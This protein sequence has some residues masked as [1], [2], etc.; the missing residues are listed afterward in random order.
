MMEDAEGN[1]RP[2]DAAAL[3]EHLAMPPRLVFLSACLSAAAGEGTK[4]LPPSAAEKRAEAGKAGE[5]VAHSLATALVEGGL[6]AVL[7]WDGP[8]A[9]VAATAFAGAFYDRLADR[10]DVTRAVAD[11]RRA[12]L[13]A[14]AEGMR[15][16]WH[17]ARLWLGPGGGGPVVGGRRKRSMLPATYG[18]KEF[19]APDRKKVRVAS[20]EMFVGRRRQLQR[21]LRALRDRRH[22]GVLVH[23]MGRLGKSSLA[24]RIA[25]RRS[26]MALAV[27]FEHYDALSVA[28]ALEVALRD[29]PPARDLLAER[30]P[31]VRADP[32][33]LETL[34]I[35]LL[36]G[37]CAQATEGRPVLLVID[38]LERTLVPSRTED[39]P[40]RPDPEHAPVLRMILSAFDPNRTDSRLFFTSRFPFALDGLQRTLETVPLPPLSDTEQRKLELRQWAAAGGDRSSS[41]G[42]E[43]LDL[44]S[45]ARVLGRG[46]PGLQDLLGQEQVLSEA[47]PLAR[48]QEVLEQTEAWLEGGDLPQDTRVQAF[49]ENLGIETLLDLAGAG[50]REL[51]RATS[52]F[53]LPVPASVPEGLADTIGGS[54]ARLRDLGLLDVFEDLVDPSVQALAVNGLALSRLEPL[55]ED[56]RETIATLVAPALYAAWGGDEGTDWRPL[57]ADWEL[58]RLGMLAKEGAVVAVC[59]ANAVRAL[60]G[61]PAKDAAAVG[62]D[63]ITLLDRLGLDAPWRL[64]SRTAGSLATSGEGELADSLLERGVDAMEAKRAAGEEVNPLEAGFLVY[65]HANRKMTRGDLEAARRLYEEAAAFAQRSGSDLSATVARG[66]IADILQAR[67]QL[68]EVLRIRTEEQLPVYERLGDVRERAVTMGKIAD[69]L[70]ARGQLDEALRIRT[71]EQLPVYERLG[72]V[73]S[74][75][76]T[77]GQIADILQARGQLDEALRIRTEEEL[78]VYERL[79]DADGIAATLWG[80]ALIELAQGKSADAAPRIAEAYSIVERIGRAE[81][82]AVVGSAFAQ[83]LAAAGEHEQALAVLRRSA[84]MYRRL[85]RS[86]DAEAIEKLIGDLTGP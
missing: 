20:H 61:G 68:D 16:D 58:T 56:E 26:D 24:A 62:Q 78:P 30:K 3:V 54:V 2:T 80:I 9:D 18:H 19:L 35:D 31:G 38:D 42:K 1:A 76:V 21:A 27:V 12:L 11:A 57:V 45:Q 70:Q 64:L 4:G 17:L 32:S 60:E 23:G 13:N 55:G 41:E 25:N 43:R 51:L 71:E 81:G 73:R 79:Q 69:I 7:G 6:P 67:G 52:L 8:V 36:A 48:A 84:E 53:A 22:A 59:A 50:G 63:A 10:V 5:E 75:A 72:D 77:M 33:A 40:H 47:M 86:D 14:A 39:R 37:P 83:I 46:N 15:R 34:L 44:L 28:E 65:E 74:R 49:L 66:K 85:G 82:I 29:Y